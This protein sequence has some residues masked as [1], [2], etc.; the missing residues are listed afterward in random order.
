MLNFAFK[1][2]P[3]RHP[4][5]VLAQKLRL[6]AHGIKDDFKD[7]RYKHSNDHVDDHIP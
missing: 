2:A 4:I 6:A 7:E 3:P 5:E 1:V